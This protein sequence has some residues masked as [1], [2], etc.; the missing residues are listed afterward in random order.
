MNGVMVDSV[1]G[2]RFCTFEEAAS[3]P[4]PPAD[5]TYMPVANGDLI[6]LV[7]EV[8]TEEYN[9]KP[10]EMPL[11]IGLSQKDQQMFGCFTVPAV[12]NER[13]KTRM[14]YAF[15][16]SYNKTLTV[17]AA[18]GGDCFAC[19]N[20]LIAGEVVEM[21]KHTTNVWADLFPMLQRVARQ[22]GGEFKA[23]M[24]HNEQLSEIEMSLEEMWAFV[25]VARGHNVL[26]PQQVNV[27]YRELEAPSVEEH[28]V[29][30]A[31]GLYNACTQ[32]LK[33]GPA[34]QIINRHQT[35]HRYCEK[36]FNL[37]YDAVPEPVA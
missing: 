23:A 33:L 35:F 16:N 14:M 25:G 3:V 19:D 13:F 9:C 27:V 17:A 6:R 20:M 26:K 7:Q 29:N 24:Q 36:K 11:T 28:A 1:K 34:G 10:E 37:T 5:H 12:S 30:N 31:F 18:S 4:V 32:G 2:G 15:R 21:R 8:L 22:A